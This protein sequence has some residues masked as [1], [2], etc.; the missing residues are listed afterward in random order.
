MSDHAE[1]TRRLNTRAQAIRFPPDMAIGAATAAYQIEGSVGADGRGESI[2]DRFSHTP[3]AIRNGDTGDAACDHYHRW[4]EDL[5]LMERLQLNAYRFSIAW[6]RVM[7]QGRG[8]VNGKGLDFYDRLVD[9]LLARGIAPFVTLYH[10]DLPQPLQDDGGGW[11]RR[12]TAD[13]FVSYADVVT[14]RLGD[15]VRCWTTFNEP[16]TFSWGGYGFGKDA[17]GLRLGAQ[18]ALAASHHALLAHG[19]AVPVIR[20]NA[21]NAQV[22][23]VFDLNAVSPASGQAADIAAAQRFDGCQNRWYLDPVFRGTYPDDMM[24]LYGALAPR[25]APGDMATIAAPL[26]YLGVNVYRRSVIADGESV[27][28]VNYLRIEPP[29]T[30]TSTGWEVHPPAI[31]DI[32]AYM[33]GNYGPRQI[34]ISENGAA[35]P[36]RVETDGSIRDMERARYVVAH[37]QQVQRAI[38]AGIPVKGYFAWTL[39]DNF[40][41]AYGYD[42]RF[43]LIHVN[44]KTQQR[45]IK[46]SGELF[47]QIAGN[48][49]LPRV[50]PDPDKS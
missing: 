45:R 39:M 48:S 9:A 20:A 49:R 37:L 22:G 40:E 15:R 12:D 4:S 38:A 24:G 1:E 13:D 25:V 8:A 33:Q 7:P 14:R 34:Y 29:G 32:L 23:I 47:G 5:A 41:W 28:P 27:P 10:W 26:D 44:F 43:G 35:F 46:L 50:E 42:A 6:P 11:L 36:D 2:W 16:W 30:Y 3:G 21:P 31:Y 17:P 19:K 18:G